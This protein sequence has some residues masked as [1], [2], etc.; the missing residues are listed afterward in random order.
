MASFNNS[1]VGKAVFFHGFAEAKFRGQSTFYTQF[2]AHP[3]VSPAPQ[4]LIPYGNYNIR[5]GLFGLD[6]TR[7]RVSSS[8][9][10]ARIFF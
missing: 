8:Y 6:S 1:V 10:N 2:F 3:Y 5:F 9:Y 7:H 4:P